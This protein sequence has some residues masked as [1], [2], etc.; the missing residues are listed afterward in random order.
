MT[1]RSSTPQSND[2][3][4]P[5]TE[6]T[7]ALSP[8]PVVG[9][10]GSAYGDPVDGLV[11]AAVADRPLEEVAQLITLLEQSPLYARATV[12]ALR[13]VGVNRSVDDV[14]RLVVLL[15][16][17]PRDVASADDAIRAAAETRPVED[18][19][20]L[21]ALLQQAPLE[22]HCGQEAVRA[23]ATGRSVEELVELIGRLAEERKG[24]P[25]PQTTEASAPSDDVDDAD[26]DRNPA[27]LPGLVRRRPA[28]PPG[29]PARLTAV[30][31]LLCAV[32]HFPVHQ[33][34]VSLR[35]YGL[36]LGLSGLCL[37]LGLLVA[38][39]PAVPVLAGAVL[40]PAAL[41]AAQLYASR[42]DSG[43]L[44]AALDLTLAPAWLAGLAAVCAALA[45]L[46]ALV[47]RLAS[48][49]PR[50]SAADRLLAE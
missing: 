1:T 15:T 8:A 11:R 41:A 32:A 42:F 38:V 16:Q 33:D 31:L 23:A 35:R 48:H 37:L 21:M 22:P 49:T 24:A 50:R 28:G 12:D 29:W 18:V 26:Q 25:P 5:A 27:N 34:G 46:T 40:V 43:R 14:T 4:I 36:V 9:G 7:G 30:A 17:P 44:S 39:R 13:A 45:A 20:R 19:T 2:P 10:S 47:V 3:A 6:I